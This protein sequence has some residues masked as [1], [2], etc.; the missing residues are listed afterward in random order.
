MD[1]EKLPRCKADADSLNISYYFTGTP[2]KRGH[3]TK[4]LAASRA[5]VECTKIAKEKYRSKKCNRDKEA[6]TKKIWHRNN[7]DKNNKRSKN[8]R[9][10]NK[11][12]YLEKGNKFRRDNPE[13]FSHYSAI[14]RAS[15]KER[16]PCWL[17]KKHLDQIK[18]IYAQRADGYHVDHI[19]PLMGEDVC[20]LHVP[21]NLQYL[22]AAENLRKSN[23]LI[24]V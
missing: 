18:T 23:K 19:I 24:G 8:W 4:R 12:Y 6:A 10:L 16:T 2:C 14:R 3:L 22:T 7:K 1:L 9:E 15:L 13:L 20:G 5:C 17:S 21:W 11:E